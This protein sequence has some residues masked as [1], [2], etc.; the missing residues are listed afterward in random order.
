M[1]N[2][3]IHGW[4]IS[5]PPDGASK[6]TSA[7]VSALPA[8]CLFPETQTIAQD[9]IDAVVGNSR[10]PSWEDYDYGRLPYL[11]ALA[12]EILRWR[13]VV[14]LTCATPSLQD[15]VFRGFWFPKGTKF[16]C[17]IWA[18]NHDS[19]EFPEADF[20][21]PE[22]FLRNTDNGIE[23]Y[24]P[25]GT[26]CDA[27]GWNLRRCGGQALAEQS[28]WSILARLLWAFNIESDCHKVR[29]SMMASEG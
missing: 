16:F 2:A 1:V 3:N 13:A 19:R 11:S 28:L 14:A 20:I 22:R 23:F 8:L 27:L 15:T 29:I 21:R 26:G 7:L 24:E 5:S 10:S 17:N 12:K 18:I 6:L 4:L 9:E 25:E